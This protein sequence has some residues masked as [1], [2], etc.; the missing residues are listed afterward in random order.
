MLSRYVTVGG[1]AMALLLLGSVALASEGAARLQPGAGRF[2]YEDTQANPGKPLP[3]WYYRPARVGTEAPVV[4]VMHGVNRN[5]SA[6]REQWQLYAEEHGFI[7]VVPEFSA[8]LFPKSH[9][10]N[11]GNVFTED[12]QPIPEAQW[13]YSFIEGVFDAIRV[14]NGLS[15]T[16]YML[17]G[18]SAGSQFVHRYLFFKPTARV[19]LAIAANA[20][21]YTMPDFQTAFPYGLKDS[22]LKQEALATA[23]GKRLVILLGAQD[24]DPQAKDLRNTPETIAQGAHRFARGQAFFA[25]ATQTAAALGVPCH[26]EVRTVPDVGHSNERMAPV[27]AQLFRAGR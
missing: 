19:R 24:T 22:G 14:A 8:A 25:Q 23:L 16:D 2:V 5:A 15:A 11:L 27:A 26:W 1:L 6:Y 20:G 3:V 4:F 7:L 17:Y 10:Y 9:G 18:H 12:G 21:W 13:S